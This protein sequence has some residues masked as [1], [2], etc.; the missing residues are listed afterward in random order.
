MKQNKCEMVG[1]KRK[2]PEMAGSIA[3]W[4]SRSEENGKLKKEGNCAVVPQP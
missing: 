4:L 3:R 2:A 1:P